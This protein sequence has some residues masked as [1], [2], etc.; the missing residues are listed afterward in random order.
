[1]KKKIYLLFLLS[2]LLT[3]CSGTDLLS[4][5]S[6]ELVSYGHIEHPIQALPNVQT[7][8]AF[9]TEGAISGIA[10]CNH[11]SGGYQVKGEKVTISQLAWTLMGCDAPLMEQETAVLILLNGRMTFESDGDSLAIFSEDGS[12]VINLAKIHN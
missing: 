3:A 8:F 11:F 1:M 7:S 4:G 12:S 5:T 2:T 10:G 6:W 9:D